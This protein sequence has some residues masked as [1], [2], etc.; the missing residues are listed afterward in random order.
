MISIVACCCVA[1]LYVHAARDFQSQHYHND[2]TW[3]TNTAQRWDNTKWSASRLCCQM[4][5]MTFPRGWQAA[6]KGGP[7]GCT[8]GRASGLH[9]TLGC[10]KGRAGG[11]LLSATCPAHFRSPP[12]RP[13]VFCAACQQFTFFIWKHGPPARPA[14]QLVLCIKK[15]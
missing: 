14:L 1:K 4:K 3:A 6:H 5:N 10:G 7:A 13:S 2:A 8:T 12:A 9:N 11:L 15:H